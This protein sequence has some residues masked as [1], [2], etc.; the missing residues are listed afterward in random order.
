VVIE[1]YFKKAVKNKSFHTAKPAA[2]NDESLSQA[3]V[4]LY[5]L[6]QFLHHYLGI[7]PLP[8]QNS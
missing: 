2:E 4:V 1:Y 6:Y 7:I 5:E 8:M 3:Q